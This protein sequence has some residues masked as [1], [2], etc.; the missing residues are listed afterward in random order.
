V[1]R[2]RFAVFAYHTFGARALAALLARDERVVA[3]VTHPDD[4]AEGD[5]FE[6]VAA[7]A[8][9]HH[10]PCLTP[11]SP[12]LP[13]VVKTLR[14][15]APDVILSVW[16]RRL[17]GAELLALPSIAALNL[18]GS[19]LPAY[20][21]RAPLNWVLV[22]GE[23]RTGVTLHHMTLEADAGDIVAQRPIDIEPDDTAAT[24]YA[25]MVASGV[26]LLL[27]AYPAVLAGTAPRI[28]QDHARATV[29]GRR[30][31]D[32]GRIE[33]AWPAPRIANM[34][35]AVARPYPGAF[36]GDGPRRLR[37]WAGAALDASPRGAAAGTLLAIVPA[38]GITVATGDGAVLLTR[39]QEPGGV[40]EAAD[41]WAVR[42]KLAPGACLAE[43]A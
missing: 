29:V 6:S 26:D 27:D 23:R 28:P 16:Y 24:L 43:L 34:I 15:V 19:L 41:A 20:R 17:L 39:V 38:Q 42:R 37:L 33:W 40:E 22:N 14:G 35:R 30:R 32:D 1:T 8:R 31:P 36:V 18:H 12:N 9:R 11:P 21:G 13:D 2:A 7:V 5:W 10:L 3:V 4:P 25:R